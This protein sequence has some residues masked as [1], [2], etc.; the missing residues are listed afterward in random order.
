MDRKKLS[1]RLTELF[2]DVIAEAN[3]DPAYFKLLRSIADGTGHIDG[4]AAGEMR[5]QLGNPFGTRPSFGTYPPQSTTP[6]IP[7]EVVDP[8]PAHRRRPKTPP[9]ASC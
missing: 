7:A 5:A 3:S 2:A 4:V 1:A 8:F 6:T 9:C